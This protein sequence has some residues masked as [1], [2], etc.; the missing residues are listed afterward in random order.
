MTNQK[1]IPSLNRLTAAQTLPGRWWLS[2]HVQ[3]RR[4]LW[5]WLRYGS[6][7]AKRASDL[8]ASVVAL[9][10][11][12]VVIALLIKVEVGRPGI[13]VQQRV[14]EGGRGFRMY[15]FRS[16]CLDAGAR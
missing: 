4:W 11:R 13:F 3:L 15:N 12:F 5:R 1:F 8:F 2:F 10:P 16:M 14:G 6:S 7:V 9:A